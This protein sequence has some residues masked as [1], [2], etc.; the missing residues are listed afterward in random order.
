MKNR[1]LRIISMILM[2]ILCITLIPTSVM[3]KSIDTAIIADVPEPSS[4]Q[5]ADQAIT[6][7]PKQTE[8]IP[9]EAMSIDVQPE[10]TKV[11]T[12]PL[13]SVTYH[14]YDV[15]QGAAA[16]MSI[17]KYNAIAMQNGESIIIAANKFPNQVAVSTEPSRFR[18]VADGETDVTEQTVYNA[19]TGNL[20]LPA[21]YMGHQIAVE[22]YCP[23]T[24]I[25]EI[26]IKVTVCTK[27][28]SEF[29]TVVTDL[30]LPSNANSI[31]IPIAESENLVVSQNGIDIDENM[32]NVK[33]GN[34][35]INTPALGGDISVSAYAPMAKKG[36]STDFTQVTH[37]RSSEQIYYGYYTSYY[38]AN[39]N[40]AF[41]LDPNVSGLNAGTYEVS[42][43]L[44]RGADDLL[45]KCAYYLYG[46]PGYD[47]VKN[48]LFEDPDSPE[49]YGLCH[50]AAAYVYLNDP[51]AF[52]GL[53]S[54][55]IN[56]LQQV[57][58]AVDMQP[59][60]PAGFD[61][62]LYNVGSATNQSL[63]SWDYTPTGN[64]EIQKIS[65]NPELTNN[66]P[67][68]SLEGAVFDVF[69]SA[70]QKIGT[71]TTNAN[72][73]GRLDG[74]TVGSGYYIIE[75]TPPKG[76]ALEQGRIS[77]EIVSGQTSSV[78]VLNKAQ[79][80]PTSIF[81]KKQDADTN[82]E[83]AQG[84]LGLKD[85]QF[86]IRYYKGYYSTAD[87]LN[88]VTPERSWVVKTND[89]GVALLLPNY[90]VSGDPLYYDSSGKIPTLPLGTMTV[91]ETKPPVGYL[92]NDELFIRRITPNGTIEAV[93]TYNAPNVKEAVI[94]GGVSIEKWDAELNRKNDVQGDGT[95]AGAV[96]EIYNRTGGDVV[97]GNKTYKPNQ[98]VHT[99]TT[100]TAGTATTVNN[101]LPYGSY[102][103]IEKTPPTGY[104]GTGVLKQM[105]EIRNNSVIVN[106][107][108]SATTI[109]NNVIR[110]GVEIEKWDAER[111]Q[112][113]LRQGDS[114]LAGAV[115]EIWNRSKNSVIVGGKEYATN[116]V[117]HTM[118]TNA[119][120]YA[121]TAT[122]VN[123]LLPYGS[124]E[125][126]EKTPPTGYLNT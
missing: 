64:L 42:S 100:D 33:G 14:Y 110:G 30:L 28:H 56:H 95:L 39:G 13:V 74:L 7:T 73:R 85:A 63:M 76:F 80:D 106:L 124:Y 43:F 115:L 46:G 117:V 50:A 88:G 91:Q 107:K 105:F 62:F 22:W 20:T 125:I 78:E 29:E 122:T 44:N 26:P 65:S 19:E 98:V 81:L 79:S 126:I 24:E 3:A 10:L 58:A 25:T 77:F 57:I 27:T 51:S 9:T 40:A 34:L 36:R 87:E 37:T 99:L 104:L 35:T 45:I 4:I 32:Y 70:D 119:D 93:S 59:M 97:V 102:E 66:N 113:K 38:T 123:N 114:T 75:T 101:L 69:D 96:F 89:K 84:A 118:T 94:R 16:V 15:A 17:H 67:C 47:S 54:A 6:P 23:D 103:I 83:N 92:N 21:G 12:Q 108:T 116:T 2:V 11:V 31:T 71:I 41:C 90:V 5:S 48:N 18:V 55:V 53:S 111:N 109:K 1:K 52:K 121:G 82:S 60:P 8:I 86:T 72:G 112:Q 49:T 120:G 61:V 68:Y